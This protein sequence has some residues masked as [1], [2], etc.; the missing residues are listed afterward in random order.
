MV[1]LLFFSDENAGT[2]LPSPSKGSVSS[3]TRPFEVDELLFFW[4]L[5]LLNLLISSKG[6]VKLPVEGEVDSNTLKGSSVAVDVVL[7]TLTVGSE[8]KPISGACLLLTICKNDYDTSNN[9]KINNTCESL[10]KD[11]MGSIKLFI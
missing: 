9:D 11:N 1:L 8:D 10:I 7:D 6:S 3:Y 4:L 5:E 2:D